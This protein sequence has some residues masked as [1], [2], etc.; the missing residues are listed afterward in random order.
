VDRTL[1]GVKHPLEA[2]RGTAPVGRRIVLGMLGLGAGGILLGERFDAALQRLGEPVNDALPEPV[3]GFLPT[4]GRFRI[5]SVV[6]FDPVRSDAEYRLTVDGMVERPLKLSLADLKT[7]TPT[8]LVKDF[9]CVTGWRVPD[10]PWTGVLLRDLLDEAGVAAGATHLKL[11]SFDTVYTE[12]LTLEQARRDDVMAAYEM[13][14]GPVKQVHGGPV[15]LYVAP[16][17]GYKSCKWLEAVE[18]TGPNPQPGYWE[19]RG[20]DVDA[21]VGR[22]NGRDDDPV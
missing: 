20:Y 19:V 6:D 22:S 8:K 13:L 2:D 9:Q 14:D 18:V 16:M 10:V 15:R 12:T 3:A 5:Y 7:M 11:H 21:W 4:S 1:D 17:Y